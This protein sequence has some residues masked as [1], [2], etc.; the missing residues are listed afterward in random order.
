VPLN[1]Q[2][3]GI[4]SEPLIHRY[5]WR[6][7][8]LYALAI[9]A[10]SDELPYL[11]EEHSEGM[12]VF[13]TYAVVPGFEAV[14]PML[15][16]MGASFSNIVHG[17]QTVRV[18]RQPPPE[19][20]L[21]TVAQVKAIY[22]LKRFAQAVLTTT[23]TLDGEPLFDTEWSII[24][25]GEGGFGG[26][27]PPPRAGTPKIPRD[28]EPDWT[29]RHATHPEQALLYRLLGDSNPLHVDAEF[30]AK[31]GFEQGPI[32][33]GLC[34]YGH[35]ARAVTS[36]VLAGDA[37]RITELHAQFRKPVWPGDTIVTTGYKVDEQTYALQA[38]VEGRPDPVVNNAGVTLRGPRNG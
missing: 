17:A 6:R 37:S 16:R 21:S 4:P 27:R 15:D 28:A 11:Y 20:E 22:D 2:L 33:H 25:F 5:D 31:L 36:A 30:A 26:E 13:P 1:A 7:Q 35:V 9:G 12:R 10:R 8:A 29:V 14:F 3:I 23:S 38:T 19:G 24:V 18:H 32:L 34:T